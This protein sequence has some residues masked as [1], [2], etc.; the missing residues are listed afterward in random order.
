MIDFTSF[1]EANQGS[2]I[3]TDSTGQILE[4]N[5]R[6][7]QMLECGVDTVTER[8]IV[9][10]FPVL[11][12]FFGR[13][14]DPVRPKNSLRY[15]EKY[16]LQSGDILDISILPNELKFKDQIYFWF[17]IDKA[18]G[19]TKNTQAEKDI[20]F[21]KK[22]LKQS[23]DVILQLD[24]SNRITYVSP[25]SHQ[26]TGYQPDEIIESGGF[27]D[28]IYNQDRNQ[29]DL[30]WKQSLKRR[31][32]FLVNRFWNLKKLKS[33][34]SWPWKRVITEYGIILSRIKSYLLIIV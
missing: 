29:F 16:T 28:L 5:K 32:K 18:P 25:S 8:N 20:D 15:S 14:Q 33:V 10:L 22:I 17:I 13:M 1:L 4:L 12:S 9:D 24:A 23:R 21:Y 27:R 2:A 26:L 7:G 3:V 19:E 6:A 34:I 11:R 30:I 31:D